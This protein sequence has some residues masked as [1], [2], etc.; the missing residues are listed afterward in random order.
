V[1]ASD[2]SSTTKLAKAIVQHSY[3]SHD[4]ELLNTNIRTLEKKH[5]QLKAVIQAIVEQSME[6]LEPIKAK[7]GVERWLE[8]IETL[9]IVTEGKVHLIH[10][11]LLSLGSLTLKDLP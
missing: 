1:Q 9:R 11:S 4:H 2:L 6:W 3:D 10:P 8:L 7:D 5:G